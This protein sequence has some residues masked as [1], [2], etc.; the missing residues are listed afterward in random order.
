MALATRQRRAIRAVLER[1]GR[2]LAAKE[3]L[4]AARVEVP[5]LGLATVYR[6][7][8]GL[9][10]EGTLAPVRLPGEAPRFEVKR[11]AHHHHFMC[12]ACGGVFE[13]EGCVGDPARLTPRGFALDAHEIILY[14]ACAACRRRSGARRRRASPGSR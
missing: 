11:R 1:A 9:T 5:R 8:R 2:P 6:T 3:V 12:R 10:D 7:L 4:A 14:G 13:V